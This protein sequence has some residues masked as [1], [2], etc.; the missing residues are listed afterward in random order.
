MK[1][2]IVDTGFWL[3]INNENDRYHKAAI[4]WLIENSDKPY[5]LVT[6]W[7]VLC[8]AFYL[9]KNLVSYSK[10]TA[11]IETYHRQE[12][13]VHDLSIEQSG[14]ILELLKKYEDI[15]LDFADISIILLAEHLGSGELLTVDNRDF[16]IL[17]W[18]RNKHFKN[19]LF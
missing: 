5:R 18:S 7:L 1:S 12:F 17:R 2:I 8:E 3:A 4:S 10:A 14:R 19:L 9:I 16:N 13:D 15:D 11:F 6:T